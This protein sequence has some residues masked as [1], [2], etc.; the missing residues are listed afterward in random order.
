MFILAL[1]TATNAGGLALSRNSEVIGV[2]MCKTPLNYAERL[3]DWIDFLLKQHDIGINDIGCFAVAAGPGSFTGLRIGVAAAKAFGQASGRPVIALSSL[4]ALAFRFRQMSSLV[5]SMVDARRQQI[6]GAV[7]ET[8]GKEPKLRVHE[9]VSRPEEWLRSLPNEAYLFVGDG[10]LLYRS[11]ILNLMPGARVAE[12]DNCILR[13]L[14]QLAYL[15]YTEGVH[16]DA[17]S[18]KAN[19]LRPPDV[20]LHSARGSD[21]TGRKS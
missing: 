10:A 6:Y 4:E 11:T 14:C 21:V 3:L 19:Y 13:E 16:T 9:Q 8:N 5:A 17:R 2:L 18:V 1:D 15:R 20:K 12:S 7:Y